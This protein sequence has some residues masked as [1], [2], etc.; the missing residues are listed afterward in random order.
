MTAALSEHPD[1]AARGAWP[2]APV[3]DVLDFVAHTRHTLP[4]AAAVAWAVSP[5]A[6]AVRQLL[7]D[8]SR[9]K[10][11]PVVSAA[12]AHAAGLAPPPSP[13][14]TAALLAAAALAVAIPGRGAPRG[15]AVAAVVLALTAVVALSAMVSAAASAA[16]ASWLGPA[17]VALVAWRVA[18]VVPAHGGWRRRAALLL[19][20]AAVVVPALFPAAVQLWLHATEHALGACPG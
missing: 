14:A 3:V 10:L 5:D 8:V 2:P 16:A 6:A 19:Q 4:P 12:A 20:P 11:P 15:S 17:C 7:E 13:A 9:G 1:P 18:A